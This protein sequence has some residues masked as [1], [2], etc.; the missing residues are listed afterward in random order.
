MA[1][2]L[3]AREASRLTAAVS[4]C[5]L[6][7]SEMLVPHRR[8]FIKLIKTG[9]LPLPIRH[10]L[11][12]P[13]AAT[14]RWDR[15]QVCQDPIIRLGWIDLLTMQPAS[16][17]QVRLWYLLWL[18]QELWLTQSKLWEWLIDSCNRTA[19]YLPS[20]SRLLSQTAL[21]ELLLSFVTPLPPF[22][23]YKLAAAVSPQRFVILLDLT[24]S[25]HINLCN[26]LGYS[27]LCISVQRRCLLYRRTHRSS[28]GN[29]C[30]QKAR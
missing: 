30:Q 28:R 5:T 29:G 23:S 19:A 18:L 7:T 10:E 3:T 12:S 21:S 27:A 25:I 4:L 6:Q 17:T 8:S 9:K 24:T 11:P 26:H 22:L 15:V 13:R 14:W 2:P 16:L 1:I 20:S